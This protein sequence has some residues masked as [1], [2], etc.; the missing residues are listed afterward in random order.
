MPLITGKPLQV[1]T[2]SF[3]DDISL[4]FAGEVG[5][6]RQEHLLNGIGGLSAAEQIDGTIACADGQPG[7]ERSAGG[8][9]GL[10]VFPE[11]GED[12]L[13]DVFRGRW[14]FE[15]AECDRIGE[16]GVAIEELRH[17]IGV[18]QAHALK[19][20][21]I[22]VGTSIGSASQHPSRIVDTLRR[23]DRIGQTFTHVECWGNRAW[24]RK[25]GCRKSNCERAAY[26]ECTNHHSRIHDDLQRRFKMPA[27]TMNQKATFPGD[28]NR[29]SFLTGATMFGLGAATSAVVIGC[30][31][32][33]SSMTTGVSAATNTDTAANILT[34][35]LIAESLAITTYYTALS[36]SG[37][38]TDQNLA[39]SGGTALN[40][41]S[42]GSAVNVAYLQGA[43]LEEVSHA[44]LLRTLLGLPPNGSGDA[45]AG[46]PQTFYFPANTFSTLSNFLPVLLALEEAFVGAY[47]TAVEEF[48]SMA[49][50]YNGYSSTQTNPAKSGA[51]LAQSDLILYAKVAAAIM[52]VESEHRAL[53]RAIPSVTLASPM[54]ANINVIPANN[55]NYESDAGLTGLLNSVS[56][57]KTTTAAAALGPFISSGSNPMTVSTVAAQASFSSVVTASVASNVTG[58]IPNAE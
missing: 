50:G 51:N 52:G 38:I 58:T 43:L 12:L 44:Q 53:V 14:I 28:L 32:N 37:V 24:A 19:H 13:H 49:A 23:G 47:M 8:N 3:H 10:G 16:A 42:G 57:D 39:G 55:L 18:A 48:S 26:S 17:G 33:G 35:A 40:V 41:S 2:D 34:A 46:V 20:S 15:D 29:R 36:S 6:R 56:G 45:A 31:S 4:G 21:C 27:E 7:G 25:S 30:G 5:G 11:A 9:E 1:A 22:T 54:Y